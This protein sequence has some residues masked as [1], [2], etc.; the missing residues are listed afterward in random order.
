MSVLADIIAG[1]TT[2]LDAIS[3]FTPYL[4]NREPKDPDGSFHR[5]F[6]LDEDTGVAALGELQMGGTGIEIVTPL[7]LTVHWEPADV[8]STIRAT[9]ADDQRLILIAMLADSNKP[10]GCRLLTLRGIDREDKKRPITKHFR[11]DARY[12]ETGTFT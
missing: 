3:G 10:A 7:L 11:F 2:V 9:V 6:L 5:K 8:E 12:T 4:P 1:Y